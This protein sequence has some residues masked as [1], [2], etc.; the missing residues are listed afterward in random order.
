ME[1]PNN[2][3]NT[4]ATCQAQKHTRFRRFF[5]N[6][7]TS[8]WIA[9]GLAVLSLALFFLLYFRHPNE[10]EH[11]W[12]EIIRGLG[13][14][15]FGAIAL[16]YVWHSLKIFFCR[17]IKR[18]WLLSRGRYIW[19][20]VP[21]VLAVPLTLTFLIGTVNN[22][23]IYLGTIFDKDWKG[24]NYAQMMYVS[25]MYGDGIGDHS[26]EAKKS[27]LCE[28][29]GAEEHSPSL[30]WMVFYHFM[31]P[32]NQHTTLSHWGRF[33]AGLCAVLGVLLLNGLLVSVLVGW[34]ESTREKWTNGDARYV[35]YLSK[36]HPYVI[37][38]GGD[39]DVHI[40]K[41][42]FQR[43]KSATLKAG[44]QARYPYI[45]IQAMSK[46][47][48]LRN[49]I[50]SVLDDD[51]QQRHVVIYRGDRTSRSDI[52]D[53]NILNAREI[54]ILGETNNQETAE[55]MHD[56]YNMRC[57]EHIANIRPVEPNKA[58]RPNVYVM[59]EHQTTFSIYQFSDMS[60]QIKDKVNF[61]PMNFYELWAL[62][63]FVNPEIKSLGASKY[64]PLEGRDGI[65][66][67]SDEFVH[68]IIVD[69]SRMGVALGIEAAHLAHYPNFVTNKRR[70]R[71]T[72]ISP[73][74]EQER[75]FFVGRFKAM[76]QLAR[77][78]YVETL[79]RVEWGDVP[80][81]YSDE[82]YG[83]WQD[84]M[85]CDGKNP[86]SHLGDNFIDVEW[87][88]INGSVENPVIQQYI[89]DAADAKNS[90]KVTIAMCHREPNV[91]VAAA[92]YLP[93]KIF[94]ADNLLQVLV[95]QRCDDSLFT[96]LSNVPYKTPFNGKIKPFGMIANAF[97]IDS[98]NKRVKASK[99]IKRAFDVAN[100]TPDEELDNYYAKCGGLKNVILEYKRVALSEDQIERAKEGLGEL[101]T[102][103]EERLQKVPNKQQK[104]GKTEVAG[105]WSS[106]YSANAMWVRRR[107]MEIG[108][109]ISASDA[110]TIML[111]AEVEHN[112][113]NTEQLLMHY[114]P[115]G[116]KEQD[117]FIYSQENNGKAKDIYKSMMRHP[118]ICSYD[119]LKLIDGGTIKNDV[120]IV[121]AA[122]FIYDELNSDKSDE[123]PRNS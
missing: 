46:V 99:Y 90:A 25:E 43:E 93:R 36:K 48:E 54:Y 111:M 118:N 44:V 15:V 30:M 22:T 106:I 51:S 31:D 61:K 72:F 58:D 56:T 94:E 49:N 8:F 28:K 102:A 32:G 67:D 19:R 38:G 103:F 77:Q 60:N 100:N 6:H 37:I 18:D 121:T 2:T 62:N 122:D 87:E 16:V 55:S 104:F 7:K 52:D 78:R 116:D 26:D 11:K 27:S 76:F 10:I 83:K 86:Y 41:S 66:A 34:F 120:H 71:I 73:N 24:L 74:M 114:A 17:P 109:K 4:L 9:I 81:I 12:W 1:T 29:C 59:F 70:T 107:C 84:P 42:I 39:M 117:I 64:L 85:C 65:K 97:D 45:I 69:M 75:N 119:R 13:V 68:L 23:I 21:F 88:F 91:A 98:I 35:K 96:T 105:W 80:H 92:I 63:V 14:S 115:I 123:E 112:R 5:L 110:K 50:Y 3:A 33:L 95:Y 113:W 82:V 108:A 89:L 47:E 20:V 101:Q 57:L 79:P 40:V 53:L